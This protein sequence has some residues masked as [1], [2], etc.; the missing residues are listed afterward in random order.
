M[1]NTSNKVCTVC[2]YVAFTSDDLYVHVQRR[3]CIPNI[4][5]S[6]V[7]FNSYALD[8]P[9]QSMGDEFDMME[10]VEETTLDEGKVYT[11]YKC[12]LFNHKLL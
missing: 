5:S 10:G 7:V 2:Q 9:D 12:A 3:R 6:E 11:K 4:G 8:S 1:S